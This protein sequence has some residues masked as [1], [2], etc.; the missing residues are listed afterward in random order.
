MLR[1]AAGAAA[2]VGRRTGSPNSQS[3]RWPHPSKVKVHLV[4]PAMRDARRDATI[5]EVCKEM[6]HTAR[7]APCAQ[8]HGR[9]PSS[10]GLV[11]ST[12]RP[13]PVNTWRRCTDA[14]G[15]TGDESRHPGPSTPTGAHA[16]APNQSRGRGQPHRCKEPCC[17]APVQNTGDSF[18]TDNVGKHTHV[19][20]DTTLQ[21]WRRRRTPCAA[22]RRRRRRPS[23]PTCLEDAQHAATGT[24]RR[25][26]CTPTPLSLLQGPIAVLSVPTTRANAC[27]ASCM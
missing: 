25:T 15:Q 8:P 17:Q 19:N 24:P 3:D 27:S 2:A 11:P 12:C 10:C 21:R 23:P 20:Q 14:S 13:G 6:A 22:G 18:A 4:Q 26:A 9:K 1:A 5:A 7:V 16:A